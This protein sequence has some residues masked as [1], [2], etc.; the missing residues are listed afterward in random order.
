M[1]GPK[2]R[3]VQTGVNKA[4][5]PEFRRSAHLETEEP[6]KMSRRSALGL[7]GGALSAA[8]LGGVP[9]ISMIKSRE[10]V[11]ESDEPIEDRM[12]RELLEEEEIVSR[13]G[14]SNSVYFNDTVEAYAENYEKELSSVLKFGLQP[15]VH[16]PE[17]RNRIE[18]VYSML[19]AENIPERVMEELKRLIIGLCF[20]ESRY[21]AARESAEGAK[22]IFQ[23]I[24]TTW[25]E[26]GRE[27]ENIYSL[28]DQTRVASELFSQT[29]TYLNTMIG[30][31][32]RMIREVY[33]T[34]NQR[35]FERYFITP[36]LINAYNAGMGNMGKLVHWFAHTYAQ[37][38]VPENFFGEVETLSGYD[39][40]FAL[41]RGGLINNP[42]ALYKEDASRYTFKVY[43]ATSCLLRHVRDDV[44]V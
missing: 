1:E 19:H 30:D 42:V 22:G 6:G 2:K 37:N 41:S 29:Y 4:G 8:A 33:F 27:D 40:F 5:Y 36:V 15:T 10:D 25:N 17:G 16:D 3:L 44:G 43:G 35:L 14:L 13:E 7:F 23:I 11:Y 31:E 39:V 28:V 9:A 21:D 12:L 38:G 32:L 34:G 18:Y 20:E 24:P 26:L